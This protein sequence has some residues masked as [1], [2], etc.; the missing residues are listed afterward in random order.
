MLSTPVSLLTALAALAAV[1]VLIWLSA[2][3]ARLAGLASRAPGAGRL[4]RVQ[5]SIAL[6]TRRRLHLVRCADRQVLLMTGGGQD[7]VVGWLPDLSVP[8]AGG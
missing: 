4:L 8:E 2:R 3:G 6:D 1:L 7:V 5:D